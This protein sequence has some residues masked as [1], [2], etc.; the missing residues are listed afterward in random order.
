[1]VGGNVTGGS[2]TGEAIE[3][4][5]AAR[6][7][8]S[9]ATAIPGNPPVIPDDARRFA[10]ILRPTEGNRISGSIQVD[11]KSEELVLRLNM[12]GLD[13]GARIAVGFHIPRAVAGPGERARSMSGNLM[14]VDFPKEELV[15]DQQGKVTAS[16]VLGDPDAIS[17]LAGRI[18]AIHRN[19]SQGDKIGGPPPAGDDPLAL[20]TIETTEPGAGASGR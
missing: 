15:A 7:E 1:M 17:Q 16:A 20:G 14:R 6:G 13:P 19:S 4:G 3:G 9:A 12:E 11:R 2:A 18:V 8:T 5:A 10:A